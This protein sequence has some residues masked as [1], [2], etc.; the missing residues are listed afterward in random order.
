MRNE[1]RRFVDNFK[2]E[3]ADTL[4][5]VGEVMLSFTSGILTLVTFGTAYWLQVTSNSTNPK[6]PVV[7]L[8][9]HGLWQNCTD[10]ATS[11]CKAL[12]L[13]G[14]SESSTTYPQCCVTVCI[15]C[16]VPTGYLIAARFFMCLALVAGICAWVIS[17]IGLLQ[18]KALWLFLASGAYGLQSK[19]GKCI[20]K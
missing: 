3:Y 17:I 10:S 11:S 14:P 7:K 16:S 13:S 9:H 2:S 1:A 19:F 5:R 8:F 4:C 6:D 20:K 15:V 12:P 18:H